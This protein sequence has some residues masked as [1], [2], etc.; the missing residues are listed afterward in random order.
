MLIE[1]AE[2]LFGAEVAVI[3]RLTGDSGSPVRLKAAPVRDSA[4]RESL[5]DDVVS[6]IV[7]DDVQPTSP[8]A[9]IDPE[10]LEL[11]ATEMST[12]I[13][14]DTGTQVEGKECPPTVSEA[15]SLFGVIEDDSNSEEGR[16]EE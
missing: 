7:D 13:S 6:D 11:S 2:K 15:M 5:P 9:G 10:G 12:D 16:S 8:S 1:V 4:Q 3:L 14:A